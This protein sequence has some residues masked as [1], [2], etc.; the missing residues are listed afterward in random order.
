[1]LGSL[2][3]PPAVKYFEKNSKIR[4]SKGVKAVVFVCALMLLGKT[5]N[6]RYST[7]QMNQVQSLRATEVESIGESC[8]NVTGKFDSGSSLTDRNSIGA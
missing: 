1:M 7:S 3:F 6:I 5:S 4:L 2:I 8:R